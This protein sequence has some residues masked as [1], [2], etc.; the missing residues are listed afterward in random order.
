MKWFLIK[1]AIFFVLVASIDFAVGKF[2]FKLQS[3]YAKGGTASEYHVCSNLIEDILVMGS[4]R[5]AHH[6]VLNIF[7]NRLG[8][9]C[10]NG[11]QDGNGIVMQYGR[12]KMISKHH[13]PK[14]LIYDIEP[15]YDLSINDNFRY[16]DRLKPFADDREVNEYITTL[17]PLERIKLFS[18]MY[19]YNYKFLEIA[20]D[21]VRSSVVNNGYKPNYNHIRP[22][23][24]AKDRKYGNTRINQIDEVKLRCLNNL[25]DEA[26]ISGVQVVLVSSP[27]WKGSNDYDFEF[28]RKLA[29]EKGIPFFDYSNSDIG[30]NQNWFADTRHLNDEGAKVF[31]IDIINHIKTI[32]STIP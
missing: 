32:C 31:T 21:C 5:A 29:E 22:E 28:I 9:T 8:L 30:N 6:Y 14:V 1:I 26:Q 20:A 12:W 2:F 13:L 11:G 25:I 16:I 27:Y 7:K 18:K 23:L 15:T 24:I 4:S 3:S 10:Y 17:F 19:R